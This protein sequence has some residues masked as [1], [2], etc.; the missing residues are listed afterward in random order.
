MSTHT[1]T[2]KEGKGITMS[3]AAFTMGTPS[4]LDHL[5]ST[6]AARN[7]RWRELNMVAQT[8]AADPSAAGKKKGRTQVEAALGAVRPLEDFFAYPGQAL[9]KVLADRIAEEDAVGVARLIRRISGAILSGSY[10]QSSRDW[11][12]E[13]DSTSA[14]DLETEYR[15]QQAL[16]SLMDH[17]TTFIV[18]QRIN[19]VLNADQILVLDRGRIMAQGS[20]QQLLE[21]SP[22]YQEIY[23]SQLGAQTEIS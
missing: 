21:R 23:R 10:R 9:L 20:H 1:Q 11:E 18:A 3:Q 12:A 7:D 6:S 5:F 16:D 22:I 14:L 15:L 17:C 2:P 4:S 13:D 8:W 19:S